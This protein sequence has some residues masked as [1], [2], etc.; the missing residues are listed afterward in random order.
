VRELRQAAAA[1]R[2]SV[3]LIALPG[4]LLDHRKT[5]R[6]T[7]RHREIATDGRYAQVRA[8]PVNRTAERAI[9]PCGQRLDLFERL[10]AGAGTGAADYRPDAVTGNRLLYW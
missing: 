2:S 4:E 8:L 3:L 10:G 7:R 6:Q 9:V 5:Q 1:P